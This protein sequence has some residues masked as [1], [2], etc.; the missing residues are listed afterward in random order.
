MKLTHPASGRTIEA[1]PE[2]AGPY[3]E[4]GW[5]EATTDAPAG[6]ASL[7]AW[8]DFARAKGF[9]ED[10]LDGKSRDDLRAALS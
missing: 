7:E 9:T 3:L 6:N 4:Q 2:H 5:R 1:R 8:Q 10:D